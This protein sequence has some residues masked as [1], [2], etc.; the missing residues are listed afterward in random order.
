MILDERGFQGFIE[1][2]Q[3]SKELLRAFGNPPSLTSEDEWQEWGASL[4]NMN[5]FPIY[6]SPYR[7]KDWRQWVQDLNRTVE[8]PQFTPWAMIPN[9]A[10]TGAFSVNILTTYYKPTPTAG[11][12]TLNGALPTGW[13]FVS[14]TL[15]HAG[16]VLSGPNPISFTVSYPTGFAYTSNTFTVQGI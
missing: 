16:A 5:G 7:Y 10:K 3:R 11:T 2:T 15:S 1:W 6:P 4:G 13:T 9:L 14:P 12:L 8:L